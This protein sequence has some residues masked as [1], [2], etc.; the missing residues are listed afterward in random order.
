MHI[1]ESLLLPSWIQIFCQRQLLIFLPAWRLPLCMHLAFWWMK[2]KGSCFLRILF[3]C[4]GG[5]TTSFPICNY[6]NLYHLQWSGRYTRLAIAS[7]LYPD[8]SHYFLG[9]MHIME[10]L[11]PAWM[12]IFS[13]TNYS[14]LCRRSGRRCVCVC[15]LMGE[16]KRVLVFCSTQTYF[17]H[18][19]MRDQCLAFGAKLTNFIV[20]AY[21]WPRFEDCDVPKAIS[22][23]SCSESTK[24]CC[25]DS[26]SGTGE[27]VLSC[28]WFVA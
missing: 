25:H 24:M 9:F 11:V 3:C 15:F 5:S 10:S 16:M 12:Q 17:A 20:E 22:A 28:R 18:G 7:T 27:S 26:T 8:H 19:S 6:V 21:W 23:L 1:L 13:S 4:F 2:W 14:I